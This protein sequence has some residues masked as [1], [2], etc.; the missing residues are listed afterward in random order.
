MA[1]VCFNYNFG[2]SLMS[3]NIIDNLPEKLQENYLKYIMPVDLNIS[4]DSVILSADNKRQI[5]EFIVETKYKQEFIKHGLKPINRL[6]F[7]GASGTGKTYLSKALTNY[8]SYT[9]LYV[10]I[11]TSLNAGT[12]ADAINATFELANYIGKAVVMFDECDAVCWARDDSANRDEASIRRATNA[13]FQNLDQMNPECVFIA[14]TNLFD[15]LD[16]AFK[17]RFNMW[18]KFER[19]LIENLDED[20]KRLLL[21]GFYIE[22]DFSE[23]VKKSLWFYARNFDQLSYRIMTDWVER[24][25]KSAI[26]NG[27]MAVSESIIYG[28]LMDAMRMKVGKDKNG[29]IYLYNE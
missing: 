19:P 26:I 29:K 3:N 21:P 24:A 6:M 23:E 28:H 22:H 17:N 8:F 9:M 15:N 25:E 18:L 7:Y 12:A 16:T 10:D 14:A 27:T 1:L 11:A 20:F 2:E 4:L 13:I 5:D